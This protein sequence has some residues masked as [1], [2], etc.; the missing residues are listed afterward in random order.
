MA[1]KAGLVRQLI[2]P[3]TKKWA[4]FTSV[5]GAATTGLFPNIAKFLLGRH[6]A[7]FLVGLLV[8]V[9]G[10]LVWCSQELRKFLSA[11]N[12]DRPGEAR[13][14]EA[15]DCPSCGFFRFFLFCTVAYLLGSTTPVGE[16]STEAIARG[17]AS[18][19]AKLETISH[20]V[21]DA[22]RKLG[23]V[24]QETSTDPRKELAN[25][26]IAWTVDAFF[27]A[28]RQGDARSVTLFL[29]G[30][31]GTNSPDSQGRPLPVM[32][33]L[34][35]SNAPEMLNLLVEA[36]L[37]VNHSYDVAGALTQ[38]RMTLLSRAIEKGAAPLAQALVEHHANINAPI[39]TFGA[40]GLTRDTYP[41]AAAIYWKRWDIAQL[42]L[43]AGAD[44][45]VGD[46]A[47]YREAHSLREK[48]KLD[49]ESKGRLDALVPHL[50]PRGSDAT[51]MANELRLQEVEQRLNQVALQGLRAAPGS[52]E[53]KR[54]DAEYDQLQTE[55]TKLRS[56]SQPR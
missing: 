16:V 22:N 44:I 48:S 35:D 4:W 39:Q 54:L 34:N 46:Y 14:A 1:K 24:K 17:L 23:Q 52:V 26:S 49:P 27:D 40:M 10:S 33:A 36:G 41:L 18:I 55:R 38:Q 29:K 42:L 56:L 53:R 37:D 3:E 21:E 12:D 32:L 30:G 50:E 25:L 47:A 19:G 11:R 28:I 51:R 13:I 9:A 15:V 45:G 43:D 2:W 31:M 7:W 5:I 20:D 6:S 8:G